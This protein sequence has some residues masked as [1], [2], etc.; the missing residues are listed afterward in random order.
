MAYDPSVDT[1]AV[2]HLATVL[3]AVY[4]AVFR[5][6]LSY[7]GVAQLVARVLWEHEARSSNLLTRTNRDAARFGLHL[8]FIF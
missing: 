5:S 8:Y 2:N 3:N 7:P 1:R 6:H 4:M